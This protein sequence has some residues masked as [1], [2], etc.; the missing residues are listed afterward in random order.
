MADITP[1]DRAVELI[2]EANG[3]DPRS[4][5]VN[6]NS[7]PKELFFAQQV[8]S[9]IPKLIDHPSE[10]LLLAAR[11][12]TIRRW[13]IPRDKYSK[14]NIGYHQWRNALAK[15]HAQETT[16]ILEKAGLNQETIARV[17]SLI[18]RRN[19]PGDPE[20][21]ALEDA[22]CLVFLQTKLGNYLD[23]WG[24]DKTI[25]ILR[26]TLKKMTP[27]GVSFV[28]QLG[29]DKRCAAIVARATA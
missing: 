5:S 8:A 29:L 22:D 10:A 17:Q 26:K 21:H 15:F 6:G 12:H 9:W 1:F 24:E 3:K 23:D 4:Q 16:A 27:K 18:T 14:D 25:N 13:M 2:D 7:V 20:A 19:F 28:A 11:S